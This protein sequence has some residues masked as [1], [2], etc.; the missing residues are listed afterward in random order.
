MLAVVVEVGVGSFHLLMGYDEGAALASAMLS[1]S[2]VGLV[3]W[4]QGR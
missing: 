1:G 3:L 4:W 2:L